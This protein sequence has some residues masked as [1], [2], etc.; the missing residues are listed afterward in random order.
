MP[1]M[2]PLPTKLALFCRKGNRTYQQVAIRIKAFEACKSEYPGII[3]E[4]RPLKNHYLMS[5]QSKSGKPV[6]KFTLDPIF[7]AAKTLTNFL[8]SRCA[9]MARSKSQNKGSYLKPMK[10]GQMGYYKL[11]AQ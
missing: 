5:S 3:E 9:G 2:P 10:S 8:K 6:L 11:V 7:N 4:L 1:V